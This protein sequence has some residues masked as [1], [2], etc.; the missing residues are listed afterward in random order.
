[1]LRFL[2][3]QRIIISICYTGHINLD[4]TKWIYIW[5]DFPLY[6][7]VNCLKLVVTSIR[8]KFIGLT[9]KMAGRGNNSEWKYVI[10]KPSN[11]SLRPCTLYTL[12][13]RA[14]Q[15]LVLHFVLYLTQS[16]ADTYLMAGLLWQVLLL[17][18]HSIWQR[19]S[20]APMYET[21]Q[22]QSRSSSLNNTLSFK[23]CSRFF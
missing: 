5:L 11:D 12:Q 13:W 10:R 9:Y 20:L 14:C 16:M 3:I 15:C 17:L 7:S 19:S 23:F 18:Q 2:I 8:G 1:M 4:S 22:K 6:I 21:K